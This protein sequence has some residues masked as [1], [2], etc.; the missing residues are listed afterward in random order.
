ML[1]A[2]PPSF[3]ISACNCFKRSARRAIIAT[4]APAR[5]SA[6]AVS[7]PIP[8]DAPVTKATWPFSCSAPK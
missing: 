8:D 2:I 4:F 5:A 6:L 1:T 7:A 3:S